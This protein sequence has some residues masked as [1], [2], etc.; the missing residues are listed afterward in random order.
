LE[1]ILE[2]EPEAKFAAWLDDRSAFLVIGHVDAATAQQRLRPGYKVASGTL[3]HTQVLWDEHDPRCVESCVGCKVPSWWIR[4][5]RP[6]YP[7]ATPVTMLMA[8]WS[9]RA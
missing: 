8:H 7:G 4:P 5:V 2:G 6:G 3:D 9:P 1:Q